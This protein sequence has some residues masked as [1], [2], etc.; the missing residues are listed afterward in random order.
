QRYMDMYGE[1]RDDNFKR[2]VFGDG[3]IERYRALISGM[4][5]GLTNP[6]WRDNSRFV[7]YNAFGPDHFARWGGWE[8]YSLH[9][10]DRVTWNWFAWEGAI[11][12]SYDNHWEP[13]KRAY[14]VWSPQTEMM[15]LV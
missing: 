10:E 2:K 3:W 9:T 14:N 8:K 4:R 7:A 15:N 6:T 5:S 12:E 11:P 13:G 1:G